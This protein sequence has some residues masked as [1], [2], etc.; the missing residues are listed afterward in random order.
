MLPIRTILAATTV[1][2]IG[3]GLFAAQAIADPTTPTPLPAGTATKAARG[4]GLGVGWFYGVLT[5]VQRTCLADAGLQRPEGKLTD[6]QAKDLR[7][8]I[9]AALAAC[10]VKIPARLAGR[11][12]LGFRWAALTG[13]QQQCLADVALT[14]PVGRLTAEQRAALRQS[15]LDAVKGCGIGG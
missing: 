6:A 5:D 2:A 9:D 13:T 8:A 11:D 7:A 4:A 1:L 14:R 12:R 15:K 3:G 10:N